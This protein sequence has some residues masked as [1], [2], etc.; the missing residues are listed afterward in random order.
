MTYKISNP[1]SREKKQSWEVER[2]KIDNMIDE[3]DS[4]A[5]DNE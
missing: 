1:K 3:G 2:D 5:E 4:Y